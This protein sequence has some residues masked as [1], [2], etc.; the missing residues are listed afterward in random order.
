MAFK[1]TI[2]TELCL[3]ILILQGSNPSF[4]KISDTIV[5][6]VIYRQSLL[7]LGHYFGNVT[8]SN[9]VRRALLPCGSG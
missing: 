6:P 1:Y 7:L 5:T 9:T 2:I 4:R 8:M 3:Y